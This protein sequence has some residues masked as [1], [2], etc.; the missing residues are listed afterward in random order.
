MLMYFCLGI[1]HFISI[2]NILTVNYKFKE[3][4]LIFIAVLCNMLK[5]EYKICTVLIFRKHYN[6]CRY[7]TAFIKINDHLGTLI[8]H[9]Y[10]LTLTI[11]IKHLTFIIVVNFLI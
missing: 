1:G 4:I 3:F 10:T 9:Y 5:T 8:Y 11:K 6:S 7:V 2:N